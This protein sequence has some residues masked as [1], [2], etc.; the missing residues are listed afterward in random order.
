MGSKRQNKQI[1]QKIQGIYLITQILQTLSIMEQV[2]LPT[3]TPV[4]FGEITNINA[5]TESA[6]KSAQKSAIK[7]ISK[8]PLKRAIEVIDSENQGPLGVSAKKSVTQT[9]SKFEAAPTPVE[10]TAPVEEISAPVEELAA[11]IEE[12][13]APVEEIIAPIE[14]CSRQ[15]T[16]SK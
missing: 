16:C 5:F 15:S 9:P 14:H 8:T 1:K 12:V 10:F 11:P 3:A 13:A 7:S 4:P 6:K 2:E